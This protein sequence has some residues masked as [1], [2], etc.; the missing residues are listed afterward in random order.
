MEASPPNL[1]PPMEREQ[2]KTELDRLRKRHAALEN[3]LRESQSQENIL[4]CRARWS[5][6]YYARESQRLEAIYTSPGWQAVTQYRRFLQ[7][8]IRVRPR[9]VA[10]FE[11]VA[12]WILNVLDFASSTARQDKDAQDADLEPSSGVVGRCLP[13]SPFSGNDEIFVHCDQP[14]CN[15][16]QS[17]SGIIEIEGWA[18]A[19][20]G[21]S[22][23][24]IHVDN[25][26]PQNARLDFTPADEGEADSARFRLLEDTTTLTNGTHRLHV[27][28]VSK[29]GVVGDTAVNFSV[30]NWTGY[31]VWIADNEAPALDVRPEAIS[32]NEVTYRPTIAVLLPFTGTSAEFFFECVTSVARQTY[33]HWELIIVKCR[34]APAE[35]D[36]ILQ[37]VCAG[38]ERVTVVIS[39][40][41]KLDFGEA[42][43]EALKVTTAEFIAVLGAQDELAAG[44]LAE[45]VR[46]LGDHPELDVLYSDEDC[47]DRLGN[48]ERPWFK[49]D[50][51]PDLLL[52]CPYVCR[53]LIC[54]CSLV[55]ETEKREGVFDLVS[56]YDLA[57]RLAERTRRWKRIPK[58]LYHRRLAR[59][60]EEEI[61][62]SNQTRTGQQALRNHLKSSGKDAEVVIIG[63]SRYRVRY[64]II[65]R[66]RVLVIMPTGGR[67]NYLQNAL[68]SVISKT[69]YRNYQISV[70]DNSRGRRVKRI[71]ERFQG[72]EIPIQHVDMRSQP[73]NFSSLC[74]SVA[75]GSQ[76][77]FYLFLNDDIT[78]LDS[79]WLEALLEHGQR[80]NVGAVGAKLLYPDG[81][82]QHAGVALG[83]YGQ[84]GHCFR[85]LPSAESHYFHFS[86]IVRNCSAVTGACLLVRRE[87]F[88]EAGGFD[89]LDFPNTLQDIDFCLQLIERGYQIV[90]TPHSQ[91]YH[92]ETGSRSQIE[93]HATTRQINVFNS[94][95]QSYIDD[96]PYYSP[97]LPRDREDYSLNVRSEPFGNEY[98]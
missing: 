17:C 51:S 19:K 78:V 85:G 3:R 63:P 75:K 25:N 69:G 45:A 52:S 83:L 61:D 23:V 22:E 13:S 34:S 44:A 38:D 14:A 91:L 66:P 7:D 76:D 96:D 46:T 74:N 93:R 1:D 40:S 88:W 65:D 6:Y 64:S 92:H 37:N 82:I 98:P 30:S 18:A 94:R 71:V 39:P 57:L 81:P 59:G 5:S 89:E 86:D 28:A 48:R 10:E 67:S 31:D 80:E 90:Y 26:P 58:V 49:P 33:P 2:T 36:T 53:L 70:V 43:A 8:K 60:S 95:W 72:G 9:L 16:E 4:R 42:Y 87:V 21:V 79:G 32:K 12:R 35:V 97:N 24:L 50:W 27:R 20:S 84:V 29:N 54:R 47:K 11:R 56:D 73:F 55:K 15:S 41:G 68:D 62:E 77:P